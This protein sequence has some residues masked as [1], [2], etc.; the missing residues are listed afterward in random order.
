MGSLATKA[1][2]VGDGKL[3]VWLALHI[4]IELRHPPYKGSGAAKPSIC[5][6]ADERGSHSYSGTIHVALH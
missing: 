6:G 4:L 2:N 1:L 5:A 3:S